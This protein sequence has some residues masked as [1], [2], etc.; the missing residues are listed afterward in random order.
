[1]VTPRQIF[2]RLQLKTRILV[3][4]M[5]NTRHNLKRNVL[6]A[7]ARLDQRLGLAGR[8]QQVKVPI[9]CDNI[10]CTVA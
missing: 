4:K 8:R 9:T 1:M 2:V 5:S 10:N 6:D 3:A 7:H